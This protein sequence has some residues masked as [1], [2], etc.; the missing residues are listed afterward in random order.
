MLNDVEICVESINVL[1]SARGHEPVSRERY[2]EIF[3][4]PVKEYYK[5]AGFNFSVE[6]FSKI[7]M[8]FIDL[9]KLKILKCD[10]YSNAK[11]TLQWFHNR[12]YAQYM[13]SAMEHEFLIES[14]N[15]AGIMVFFKGVSGVRDHYANGKTEMAARYCEQVGIIPEN[16]VFIGDTLHDYEVAKALRM[17]CFLV[18][19]GHQSEIKLSAA[20]CQI[21][22]DL[23]E[24]IKVFVN[25]S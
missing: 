15:N 10:I 13:I 22:S 11:E 1:L 19:D 3:T 18:A 9:Y 8:E 16:S 2:K 17:E 7:A 24:L 14:V 23:N 6:P 5:K 25:E 12:G 4:F 20:K 21:V